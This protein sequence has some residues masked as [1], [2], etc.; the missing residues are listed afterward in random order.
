MCVRPVAGDR[1]G[2]RDPGRAAK[3]R[4][5]VHLRPPHHDANPALTAAMRPNLDLSMYRRSFTTDEQVTLSL[6]AFNEKAVAFS[7]YRIDLPAVSKNGATMGDMTKQTLP[8]F[9]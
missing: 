8:Q 3:T 7:A 9:R 6:S 2:G 4:R 1:R 5:L